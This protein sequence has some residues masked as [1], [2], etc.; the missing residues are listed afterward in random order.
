VHRFNSLRRR[1][2]SALRR[3]AGDDPC[4]LA[5]MMFVIRFQNH[6]VP[7]FELGP[8]G[9]ELSCYV[10][11]GCQWRQI[12]YGQGEGQ[13]EIDGRRWSF[14]FG[15]NKGELNVYLDSGEIAA[16]DALAF[17]TAV[18]TRI[19]GGPHGFDVYLSGSASPKSE[20]S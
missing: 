6:T 18:A 16:A 13:V 10:P 8:R 19:A 5:H 4:A 1:L 17:V 15:R 2:R 9:Q 12:N 3:L 11:D 7:D 14:Y 20:H